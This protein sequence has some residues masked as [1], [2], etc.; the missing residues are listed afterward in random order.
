MFTHYF[1]RI[2]IENCVGKA[3]QNHRYCKLRDFMIGLCNNIGEKQN[4]KVSK[5]TSI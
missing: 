2:I 4:E 3:N 5:L 1:T